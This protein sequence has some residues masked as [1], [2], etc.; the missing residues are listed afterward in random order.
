M[1]WHPATAHI[2]NVVLSK[3][4]RERE[5]EI[6][7]KVKLQD[8]GYGECTLQKDR[9]E[10]NATLKEGDIIFVKSYFKENFNE[11]F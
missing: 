3:S 1:F 8:L 4:K 6:G 2:N 11:L 9:I 7:V 10:K 5:I